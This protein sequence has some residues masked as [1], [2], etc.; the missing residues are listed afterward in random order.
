MR[1]ISSAIP[2]AVPYDPT[3]YK[4]FG[5]DLYATFVCKHLYM[6]VAQPFLIYV[7]MHTTYK[8]RLFALKIS[9]I[10]ES[11]DL[12]CLSNAVF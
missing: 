2:E 6:M 5:K 1:Y 3:K 11:I 9:L 4:S 8:T 7:R 12:L 10:S